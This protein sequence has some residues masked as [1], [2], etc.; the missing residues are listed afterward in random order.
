MYAGQGGRGS[1]GA[2]P[3]LRRACAGQGR[4]AAWCRGTPYTATAGSRGGLYPKVEG[5]TAQGA[6]ISPQF[7]AGLAKPAVFGHSDHALTLRPDFSIA[8][9]W[10]AC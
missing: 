10:L 7:L 1:S 6:L 2:K 8:G 9:I 5:L 3:H 4:G